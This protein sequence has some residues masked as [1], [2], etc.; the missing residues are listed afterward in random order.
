MCLN[1]NAFFDN[2]IEYNTAVQ[3]YQ[4]SAMLEL[5]RYCNGI[6]IKNAGTTLLNFQG[7]VMQPG[8]SK[9]IGGNYGEIYRGRM[10]ISFTVQPVPPAFIINMAVVTQKFYVVLGV[11]L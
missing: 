4:V 2:L 3:I 9:T 11:T 6:I 10:D 7:D 5:D 1:K 8:D